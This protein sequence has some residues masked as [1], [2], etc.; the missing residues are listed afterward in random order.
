MVTGDEYEAM[1]ER[2]AEMGFER[3][4]IMAALQASFNNPNR[5][6]EYL[7]NVRD[8][9]LKYC[10]TRIKHSA[11]AE[12]GFGARRHCTTASNTRVARASV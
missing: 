5:A 7:M 9:F 3:S 11:L 1:I 10:I 4:Q 12:R 8:N 2:I 6:I